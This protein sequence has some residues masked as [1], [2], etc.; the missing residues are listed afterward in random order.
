MRVDE[1]AAHGIDTVIGAGFDAEA[2]HVARGF[3]PLD[4]GLFRCRGRNRVGGEADDGQH[5]RDDDG[6]DDGEDEPDGGFH[7]PASA[8]HRVPPST[9]M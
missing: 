1:L 2:F 4:D 9:L 7:R 8:L 3:D 6:D 5:H